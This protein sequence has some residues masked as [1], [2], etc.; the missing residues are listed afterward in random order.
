VSFFGGIMSDTGNTTSPA[1]AS[2]RTF[3]S[4]PAESWVFAFVLCHCVPDPRR[5]GEVVLFDPRVRGPFVI[6]RS[7]VH[8]F[9]QRPGEMVDC[10]RLRGDTISSEQ[11]LVSNEGD[12]LRVHNVG[13][14]P[15]FVDGTRVPQHTSVHLLPG[16]VVEVYGHSMFLVTR[17]PLSL[18]L[19]HR[20]LV[21]LQPFGE[22]DSMGFA[23]ES[24]LAWQQREDAVSAANAGR[25]VLV[26]GPTGTGKDLV[27]RAIH[28]KS[29]RAQGPYEVV[30]CPDLTPELAAVRLFGGRKNWPNPGTP[31]TVGYFQAAEGGT[32]FL[33]EIGEMGETLQAKLLGALESGYTVVGETQ[34]RPIRCVVVA[35]TNRGDAGMKQDVRMRFGVLVVTPSLAERREDIAQMISWLLLEKARENTEF[36]AKFLE[37]DANGRPH[38]RVDASLVSGLL[39][40]PLLGNVRELDGILGMAI[41][42][43]RGEPPLRWPSRLPLP[44]PSPLQIVQERPHHSADELMQGLDR[45][46][47]PTV[48]PKIVLVES[49]GVGSEDRPDPSK[50]RVL[51][52]LHEKQWRFTKAAEALGISVDKLFRLREK[53]GLREP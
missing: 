33:D 28:D 52:V 13:R 26:Y 32:L 49:D 50:E 24:P 31:E 20:L 1:D 27:A 53:Y 34:R 6:G 23:G 46:P 16:A 42:Q 8:F 21:P 9:Q 15:V 7:G 44:T 2:E 30:N 39:R 38:V 37:T 3:S 47:A 17:R 36:A 5:A 11:L 41:D 29:F 40:H 35:A 4:N 25:N 48:P 19:A 51:E 43:A 22:V 14:A 10:G 18:P 45:R 12:G